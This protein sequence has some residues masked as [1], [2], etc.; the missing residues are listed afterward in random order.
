M[1]RRGGLNAQEKNLPAAIAITA[2]VRTTADLQATYESVIQEVCT[3][4]KPDMKRMDVILKALSGA[5]AVL[6]TE[7]VKELNDTVLKA[8]G[9]GPALVILEGLKAGRTRRLPGIPERKT[10]VEEAG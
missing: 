1:Q 7:A 4:K 5:N 9:H 8:E 6:Q 2:S 10:V 3:A